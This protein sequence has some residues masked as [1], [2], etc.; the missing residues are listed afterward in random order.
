M[1]EQGDHDDPDERARYR[2]DH[3]LT[4]RS[5]PRAA[6]LLPEDRVEHSHSMFLYTDNA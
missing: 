1:K 5:T 3:N 6:M 2:R 4:H